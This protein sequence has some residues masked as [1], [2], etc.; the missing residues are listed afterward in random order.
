MLYAVP[1][2]AQWQITTYK[3]INGQPFITSMAIADQ[4][5]TGALPTRFVAT[6]TVTQADLFESGGPGQFTVNNPFPGMDQNTGPGDTDDFTAR[7]SG[8]LVVT[9]GTYNFWTDSDDGNRFRLDLNQN[10]TFEDA[11]ESIVP[12]GG[13]QGAGDPTNPAAAER[14]G[15]I[16]LAAGNYKFE[17]T[18]FERGGGASIDA[19]YRA[20][21]GFGGGVQK[22]LGDSS[23][24]IGATGPFSIR[25]VGGTSG[26]GAGPQIVNYAG[27]DALRT[28]PNQAGFP[29]T[30]MRPVFN[31]TDSGGQADFTGDQG[32]PGLGAPDAN[33]DDD[34]V[35]VGRGILVV[36]VG[37][38]NGVIFRSNTDDGGRLLIDL[39]HDGDFD[40]AGEGVIVH[41]V[42][43]G[44]TNTDS[45]PI[46]LAA[47]NYLMEYSFF[48]RG[49]GAEG[50]VSANT[51]SG[52]RLLGDTANG[53]LQVNAVPEPGTLSVL[54]LGGMTLLRRRRK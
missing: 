28:S 53:G 14:S 43:Q 40:D 48:E 33:D 49:G 10:G 36:P 34:F 54:A 4:Y 24:G 37:G 23:S 13:L 5:Y 6:G 12:D 16:V 38:L 44:P 41:D 22:L 45:A 7:I 8:T 32:A 52:F 1:A 9:A 42:L 31:I 25:V 39:N 15:D 2:H 51:G 3:Q 29:V 47:G 26:Q 17:V 21:G 50:E 35:A 19:G 27:A 46:N 18:M 11:T 30:E 20:V